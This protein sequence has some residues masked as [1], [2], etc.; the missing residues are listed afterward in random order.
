MTKQIIKKGDK[1]I[2]KGN[3]MIEEGSKEHK[4]GCN[5]NRIVICIGTVKNHEISGVYSVIYMLILTAS[6]NS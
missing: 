2:K 6:K 5:K 3:K 1:M 4:C